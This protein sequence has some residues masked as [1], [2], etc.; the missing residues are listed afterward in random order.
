VCKLESSYDGEHA[1]FHEKRTR[2][3]RKPHQCYEC[4]GKIQ[5][6]DKYN[7]VAG[8]WN[9]DFQTY[10]FCA[11]CDA[12]ASAFVAAHPG[13]GRMYGGLDEDLER[14]IEEETHV[15][16]NDNEVVSESGQRWQKALDEM[17]ARAAA[18]KAVPA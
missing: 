16:D 8:K 9:G 12:I 17:R 7:D 6:G 1:E 4:G 2:T 3:A 10:S 18:A 15:D 14:C 13:F 11:A 5:P